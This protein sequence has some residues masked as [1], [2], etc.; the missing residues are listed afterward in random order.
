MTERIAKIMFTSV[1]LTAGLLMLHGVDG[2]FA[3]DDRPVGIITADEVAVMSEP[4][5]HGFLQKTLE[6]GSQVT[7]IQQRPG[8]IQILHDGE[9]GFIQDPDHRIKSVPLKRAGEKPEDSQAPGALETRIDTIKKRVE[10]ISR[11]IE[12]GREEVDAFTRKETDIVNQLERVELALND[13][14]QRA[15]ALKAEIKALDDKIAAASRASA[16]LRKQIRE[17]EAYVAKRL[18]A[19]YKINWL[20]TF[21]LLASAESMHEFIQRK[22]ALEHILAYDEKIRN[23]LTANQAELKKV[24][25]RLEDHKVRKDLRAAE[26]NSHIRLMSQEQST[27]TKLLAD[28][29]SQKALELAAIDALTQSANQLDEEIKSLTAKTSPAP[30]DADASQFPFSDFKGLLNMPVR[31]KITNLFGQYKNPKYNVINFRSGIDIEADRGE[32]I[33]CV[34]RGK[35][36]YSSWFKGYGNMII[37][38]HGKNYYTVYAHLE[39]VFKPKGS[40]VEAGDIIATVGDTGSMTGTKLYFEVRHHG[41]P[42][43]PL[44]WLKTG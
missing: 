39:E 36:I 33:R 14:R 20:G 43:D 31:G 22:V 41:K 37:I 16:E 21:H 17:N 35:V 8:W 28:I 6:Q 18:V 7:I 27:R 24:L 5:P 13:S 26:Y 19:L 11:E 2:V 23:T 40:A 4:G 9:I 1:F 3:A 15:S 34:F 32:P 44:K 25:D 29:R 12:Q 10:N 38:D 30:Q 42:L